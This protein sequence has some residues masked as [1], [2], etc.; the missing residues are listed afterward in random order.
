MADVAQIDPNKCRRGG[1]EEIR[2]VVGK[3]P[4]GLLLVARSNQGVCA[5]LLGDLASELKR[6]LQ[7]RFP[8]ATLTESKDMQLSK[9]LD[10][11]HPLDERG[12]PFQLKVWK[13]LR[14]I[15][16]GSTASYMDIAKKIGLPKAVRAVA[17]ACAANPLAIITP[18][19]RVIRSD[20]SLSGYRWGVERKK[21]L[22][23]QERPNMLSC[24]PASRAAPDK[25]LNSSE[26]CLRDS[27]RS[28]SAAAASDSSCRLVWMAKYFW[29]WA[30]SGFLGSPFWAIR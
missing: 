21:A 16:A 23:Q 25:A 6:E 13:A 28:R 10:G 8:H 3:S 18:C 26:A 5:V 22:L 17:G 12:T 11:N 27:R 2:F 4:L 29:A 7:K 15:P 19:H 1:K 20:G 14:E 30:I 9:V 24:T